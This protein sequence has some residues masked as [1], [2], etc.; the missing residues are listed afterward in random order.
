MPHSIRQNFSTL[1]LGYTLIALPTGCSFLESNEEKSE[2]RAEDLFIAADNAMRQ[3]RRQQAMENFETLEA[4]YPFSPHAQ[5][6]T[7]ALAYLY[8]KSYRYTEAEAALEKFIRLNPKNLNLDYAYYL[9]G[10]THYNHAKDTI[11]IIIKRDRS[12]KDPTFMIKAFNAFKLLLEQYPQ[13]KYAQSAHAY[14]IVL[15]NIL[16]VYEVRIADFYM[17]RGAYVAVVN[18]CKYALEHYPGAQHTPQIIT[19][20]AEA[21]RQLG[22]ESLSVDALEVLA[23]NYPEYYQTKIVGEVTAADK[24]NWFENLQD[25]ADTIAEKL[26]IKPRY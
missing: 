16:A 26:K 25:L 7:L 9:K 3:G 19:L 18:R 21:Y 17:R 13:S 5:Q 22:L 12:S 8:Y 6:V 15:R 1:L 23:L 14:I 11:N 24:R 10:L 4:T 2:Q 20:L